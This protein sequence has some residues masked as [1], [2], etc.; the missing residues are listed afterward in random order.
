MRP[1][2]PPATASWMLE[3]L[4]PGESNRALA[5]D[6]HEEFRSGR[7]KSWYWRQ[8]VGAISIRVTREFFTHRTALL[9]AALWSML[10][11]AW[12]LAIASLEGYAN[13]NGHLA[14]LNWPWNSLCGFALMLAANLIFIWLGIALYLVPDLWIAGNLRLRELSRVLLS[15]LRALVVVSAALIVLPMHFLAVSAAETRAASGANASLV[16]SPTPLE[17]ARTHNQKVWAA[18]DRQLAAQQTAMRS[19][20][21]AAAHA[22]PSDALPETLIDLRTA[23]MAA[24]LPFFLV[25]LC[26]LWPAAPLS[27]HRRRKISA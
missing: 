25:V 22:V 17:T 18:Y 16:H 12:L 10:A 6:L 26:A 19:R 21:I 3:H 27:A 8:V 4:T 9:F 1:A 14:R 2:N 13:L 24:R 5:G 23:T 15:S 7:S 11:P 20:S